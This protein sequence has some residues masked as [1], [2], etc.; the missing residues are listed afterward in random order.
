MAACSAKGS[1]RPAPAN[2]ASFA[3][4]GEGTLLELG[5]LVFNKIAASA[6]FT[7][8]GR[9]LRGESWGLRVMGEKLNVANI[10]QAHK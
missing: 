4:L 3:S 6:S 7:L 1:P 10:F 9:V 5:T 8:A 2:E